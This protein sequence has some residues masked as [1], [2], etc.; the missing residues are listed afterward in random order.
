M[1]KNNFFVFSFKLFLRILAVTLT[2]LITSAFLASFFSNFAIRLFA[3]FAFLLFAM[4]II[5]NFNWEPGSY[6]IDKASKGQGNPSVFRGLYAGLIACIP[7]FII[8]FLLIASK[9]GF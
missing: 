2:C 9:I 1:K 6:D 4:P 3:G 8:A 7:L 5:F